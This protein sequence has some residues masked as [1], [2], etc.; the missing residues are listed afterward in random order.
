M[1][2]WRD[3]LDERRSTPTGRAAI[4]QARA[5]LDREIAEDDELIDKVATAIETGEGLEAIE[6]SR[7][8]H[9]AAKAVEESNAAAAE[10][11]PA[12]AEI[13]QRSKE[14]IRDFW[15]RDRQQRPRKRA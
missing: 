5:K 4:E 8:R 7:A 10:F 14:W 11:K 3:H 12:S 1:P 6:V 9:R 2:G 13:T 15:A